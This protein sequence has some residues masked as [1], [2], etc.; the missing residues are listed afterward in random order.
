MQRCYGHHFLHIMLPENML[1]T[2]GLSILM[3]VVISLSGITSLLVF[4][5]CLFDYNQATTKLAL[6]SNET[7]KDKLSII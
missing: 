4:A 6:H 5:V 2:G 1:I 3:H 7:S